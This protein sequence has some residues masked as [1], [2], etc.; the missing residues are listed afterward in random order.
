MVPL[1]CIEDVRRLECLVT[2]P[3]TTDRV[4]S[5][6]SGRSVIPLESYAIGVDG[7]MQ[8]QSGKARLPLSY[9]IPRGYEFVI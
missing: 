8:V 3:I 4:I 5:M 1:S 9:N 6:V 2:H 7:E